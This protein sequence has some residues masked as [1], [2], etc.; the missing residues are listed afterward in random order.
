MSVKRFFCLSLTKQL[1]ISAST[2]MVLAMQDICVPL[3][4][5]GKKYKTKQNKKNKTCLIISLWE[6]HGKA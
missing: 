3:T 4:E 6:Q 5:H 2:L 1:W